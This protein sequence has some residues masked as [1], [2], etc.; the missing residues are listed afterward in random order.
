MEHRLKYIF[1]I[2]FCFCRQALS[3]TDMTE[4]SPIITAKF[5]TDDIK[6][7][8]Y[9]NKNKTIATASERDWVLDITLEQIQ[10]DT[11]VIAYHYT[12]NDNQHFAIQQ[13]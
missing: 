12:G 1:S 3:L 8:W 5:V 2:L 7:Q 13:S 11:V 10:D 6:Q 4:R 9:V